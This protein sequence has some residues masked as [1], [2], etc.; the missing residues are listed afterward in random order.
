MKTIRVDVGHICMEIANLR[1]SL[2]FYKP[3]LAAAGFRKI[4][5]SGDFAGFSNG[6][7]EIFINTSKPRRVVRKAPSGKEFV[8]SDHLAFFVRGRREV[9]A[10]TRILEE[11]GFR[12]LFPPEE[13]PEFT[14]GYYA[15]SFCDPDNNVIEFYTS[16]K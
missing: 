6:R 16:P 15:V 8:V 11:A 7:F 10:I 12:P 14:P 5:G 3:L 13:H 4:M 2:R 1:Q 9:D